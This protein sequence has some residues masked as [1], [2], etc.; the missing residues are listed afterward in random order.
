MAFKD[1][2]SKLSAEEDIIPDGYK[3]KASSV[4]ALEELYVEMQRWFLHTGYDWKETRYLV[5]DMPNGSRLNEISWVCTRKVDEYVSYV[6]EMHLKATVSEVEVTIDNTK[7]KMDKGSV[8][9]RFHGVMKKNVSVWDKKFFGQL[10]RLI[11]EKILISDRLGEYEERLG[12]ESN[13]FFD[14]I[15]GYLGI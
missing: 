2:F 6:F 8:E 3:I 1:M 12:A 15:K 4:F 13:A 9:Y 7:K 11:Y 5:S 14:E 10:L